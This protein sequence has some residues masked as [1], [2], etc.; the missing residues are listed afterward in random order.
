[1]EIGS[2]LFEC[3]RVKSFSEDWIDKLKT[4][5]LQARCNIMVIVTAT[6]PK[7]IPGKFGLKNGVFICLFEPEAIRQ[8][9]LTLRFGLLKVFEILQNQKLSGTKAE[10]LYNF[11][12]S[13]QF[14]SLMEHVLKGF[15]KLE[16]SFID[17]RK[18]LTALWK[19]REAHVKE[20]LSTVLELFGTMRGI[21]T[22]IPEVESL[23]L[24]KVD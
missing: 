21:S 12:T 24:P 3:K 14:K 8:L 5:N 6:M 19:L 11:L 23:A 1:M 20:M 18:K 16:E 10:K 4:D 15:Q 7:D 17:E 13:E 22:E 2:I 9:V